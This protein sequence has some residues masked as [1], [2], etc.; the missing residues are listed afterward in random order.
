LLRAKLD[1]SEDQ[2]RQF[3]VQNGVTDLAAQK[4]ALVN[5]LSELEIQNNRTAAESV[6]SR[7]RIAELSTQLRRISERIGKEV[8]SVQN[9]A[10]QQLKPQLMQLKPERADLLSR[11]QPTSQCI[12]QINARLAAA[13]RILDAKNHL[14]VQEKSSDINPVSVSLETNLEQAKTSTAASEAIQTAPAE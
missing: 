4:Q 10:L 8:R 14:E 9:A 3:E 7:E 1:G 6:S 12:Q 2:L 5:R 13:Q 11:Y